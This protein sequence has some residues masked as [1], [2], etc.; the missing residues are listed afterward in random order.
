EITERQLLDEQGQQVLREL[1]NSGILVAIDDFGT[2]RTALS[3]L[4]NIEF[5]FLKI[6]KCFVD[7]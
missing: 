3:V 1:R 7:T 5:D 2:G 4:Q 6:D